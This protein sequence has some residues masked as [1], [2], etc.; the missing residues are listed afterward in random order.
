MRAELGPRI[1]RIAHD[2][3]AHPLHELPFERLRDLVDHDE[4][5]RRDAGLSVVDDARPHAGLDR[6]VEI[7]A[8]HHD[9]RIAAAQ[10]EH[11]LLEMTA[12]LAR[13]VGAG[14]FTSGQRHRRDARIGHELRHAR[15]VDEQ[16][17][18]RRR[19]GSR[20][21]GRCLRSA[22]AHC[23]TFD[24]CLSRTTLPAISAGAATRNT[25]QNGKFHGM[26][27]RIAPSG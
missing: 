12:R 6:G 10:F 20:R 13:D 14:E 7:G 21:G 8:R 26:I 9:E 16:R 5:L 19:A 23:G 25:C 11:D 15:D 24:A 3:R 27:A 1:Q 17:L 22:S 2:H 18:E 4:A